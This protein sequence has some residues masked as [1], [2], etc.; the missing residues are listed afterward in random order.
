MMIVLTVALCLKAFLSKATLTPS[1]Q[2]VLKCVTYSHQHECPTSQLQL[3]TDLGLPLP[4]SS[5]IV[6]A[7]SKDM[8]PSSAETRRQH[9][10]HDLNISQPNGV[11]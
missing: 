4:E 5:Y 6:P 1:P 3:I 2:A 9:L 10:K 11:Q 8:V 7:A